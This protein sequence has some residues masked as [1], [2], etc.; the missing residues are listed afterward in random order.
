MM[1][2]IL[3]VKYLTV[4]IID[5]EMDLKKLIWRSWK[6]KTANPIFL[7]IKPFLLSLRRPSSGNKDAP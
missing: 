3:T 7:D 6:G 4:I 1:L 5:L 2:N